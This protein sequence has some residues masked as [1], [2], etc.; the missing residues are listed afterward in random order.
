M[1]FA[2]VQQF[3]RSGCTWLSGLL[4]TAATG[5]V[6]VN[7]LARNVFLA[8][9]SWAD[10]VSLV[11]TVASVYL[12]QIPLE[13]GGEQ[14]N[15][16]VVSDR[17]TSPRARRLYRVLRAAAGIMVY[18]ALIPAARDVVRQNVAFGT[19]TPVLGIPLAAL[20]AL[21]AAVV[22]TIVAYWVWSLLRAFGGK[23]QP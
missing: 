13:M 4:L 20:Y 9:I 15:I 23:I 17:W 8:P 10:E 21:L 16:T 1:R 14:L 7:V 22:V 6:F 11:A 3:I 19:K 12:V 2:P 18:G 5:L